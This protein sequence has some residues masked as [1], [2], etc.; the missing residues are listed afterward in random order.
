MIRRSFLVFAAFAFLVGC[1]SSSKLSEKSEKKL[2]GGNAW[3]A[4]QLATRALDKEPGNPRA[5][6]AATAAGASIVEE[7]Q[8]KIRALAQVDS[9]DAAEEALK[10]NDFRAGAARYATLPVGSG[11]PAEEQTLRATA[12]RAHYERGLDAAATRRPKRACDEFNESERFVPG[13]RD[14]AK[15]A[16]RALGD[17]LTR[18]AVLPFRAHTS[19]AS[20][21]IQVARAWRDDLVED[22]APPAARFTRVLGGNAADRDL[23]VSEL[24]S[25]SREEAVR[26][27]RIRGAQRVVWGSIG[28]VRSSTKLH[29]FRDTVVR[30]VVEKDAQGN[31]RVRWRDVPIEVVAR[32]RDV[33]VDVEYEVIETA[34]GTSLARRWFDR[35]TSARVVWTSDDLEGDPASYFL[36]SE[37]VRASNP[38]RVRDVEK[39]WASV[40]GNATTLAQVID[41]RRKTGPKA[42][43]ARESLPKFVAGTAFVFLED[44][45][46]AEDLALSALSLVSGPLRDDLLR[47]D[48]IDDPDLGVVPAE[49]HRRR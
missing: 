33:T 30:R 35:S 19:D 6:M 40:C 18:V 44:L 9:L 26:L 41:A 15:R 7:W 2:A 23:R 38:D 10:L 20:I 12:A 25:L 11:W 14:A 43:Y 36:V 37:E 49:P 31:E 45:P 1:A 8:R 32:V 3:Q 29:L 27:G 22:L 17:A 24:E 39:R 46:P 13:Y 21:G 47:L 16:D 48:P 4:W 34:N 42:R 5:R 28:D